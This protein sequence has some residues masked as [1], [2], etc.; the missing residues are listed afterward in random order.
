MFKRIKYRYWLV[1]LPMVMACAS[2]GVKKN[3]LYTLTIDEELEFGRNIAAEVK[4]KYKFL[5]Q[6]EVTSY[7]NRIGKAIGQNSDWSGLNYTVQIILSDEVFHFSLPGGYIY[8]STGLIKEMV[9]MNEA[10][11]ILAYEIAN[12]VHHSAS[13]LLVAKF[14][15]SIF[16]QSVLGEN[17]DIWREIVSELFGEFSILRFSK[18]DNRA[19]DRLALLYLQKSK[20][21]PTGLILIYK[22]IYRIIIAIPERANKLLRTNAPDEDRIQ[23]AEK[24]TIRA[25]YDASMMTTDPDFQNIKKILIELK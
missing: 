17:P 6:P 11:A 7:F 18:D 2:S 19:A 22:T 10:A 21:E 25:T 9:Q 12:V 13:R 23:R 8:L 24:W 14:G 3:E 20:I 5:N 1:I 16:S 4:L 15:S